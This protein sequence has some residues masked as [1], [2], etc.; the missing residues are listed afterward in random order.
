VTNLDQQHPWGLWVGVDVASG[1]AL[2]AGGFA[3]VAMVRVF[4]MRQFEPLVRPALLTAL[5]GYTAVVTGLLAD[6]GRYYN[7]WHP[8]MPWM[9]QG[10]SVLFEVGICE[11]MCINLLYLIFAP[12]LL[13]RLAAEKTRF[14][15]LSRLAAFAIPVMNRVN[16][17]LIIV[18]LIAAL[19]H[20]SALG[21]L[22]VLTPYKL[23][24]LWHTPIL[25][26]LFL[27]SAIGGGGLAMMCWESLFASWSLKIKPEMHLLTP[28]AKGVAWIM[29]IYLVAKLADVAIRGV[30]TQLAHL[31]LFTVCW[32]FEVIAGIA[33]PVLLL[34]IPRVRK[35]PVGL[36]IASTLIV[37][38]I[39]FNRLNI[40][41]IAY[42][43]PYGKLYVPSFGEFAISLGLI[44]FL[45]LGY[46]LV[47]TVFPVISQPRKE[48][49]R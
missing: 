39:I 36:F 30:W 47:V 10:N 44:A 24:A 43:P 11:V 35:S 45:M 4:H 49:A 42:R 41:V 32:L 9:W 23:N 40:F 3:A 28:L 29:A 34:A 16:V 6:L 26:A 15:R 13:E 37:S 7:V 25:S 8:L 46:R 21:N 27:V 2:A 48:V 38:G 33:V 19:L 17:I 14:P 12:V 18:G 5:L 22:L 20:Q 31:N 1:V